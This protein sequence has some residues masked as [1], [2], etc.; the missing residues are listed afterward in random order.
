MP[1]KVQG[2]MYPDIDYIWNIIKGSCGYNCSYCS[3]KKNYHRFNHDPGK[4]RLDEKE[5]KYK[6]KKDKKYF[7][8]SSIDMWHPDIDYEWIH[9][10]LM[11]I[12]CSNG[13]Y[14]FQTKNPER[15]IELLDCNEMYIPYNIID[16]IELCTTIESNRYYDEMGTAPD[17]IN[18]IIAMKKLRELGYKTIITIEPIMY[19][20][21]EILVWLL[22]QAKP[23]KIYIGADSKKSELWEPSPGELINL[24]N[25]I[26][27]DKKDGWILE[28]IL[29][30]NLKR[31]IGENYVL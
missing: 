21:F 17:I 3:I 6:P 13:K 23:D 16:K 15:Y 24:I 31:I 4:L 14:I 19:F 7:I 26:K 10:I 22:C 5:F 12:S 8:G 11:Y 1:N 27:A 9:R 18:R 29:K 28:L 30:D 2:N 20:D 25:W